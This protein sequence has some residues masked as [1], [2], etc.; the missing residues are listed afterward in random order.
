MKI[1]ADWIDKELS[2]IIVRAR[3]N[4]QWTDIV[5]K[6][7]AEKSLKLGIEYAISENAFLIEFY[8]REKV[9]YKKHE[10]MEPEIYQLHINLINKFIE[11]LKTINETISIITQ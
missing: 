2:K 3:Y 8:E 11:Q 9:N 7:I 5:D 4:S 6:D 1:K 10:Q